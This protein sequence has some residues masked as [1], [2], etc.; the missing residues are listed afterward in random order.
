MELLGPRV[1][2]PIYSAWCVDST[3]V[4]NTGDESKGFMI[5]E[6]QMEGLCTYVL[7]LYNTEWLS[8]AVFSGGGGKYNLKQVQFVL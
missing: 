8:V 7:R 1:V 3:W 4:G 6:G 5:M 2:G